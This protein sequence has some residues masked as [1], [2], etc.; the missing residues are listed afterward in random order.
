[1]SADGL[2]PAL[3][4]QFQADAEARRARFPD[5]AWAERIVAQAAD[6]ACINYFALKLARQAI[7]HR[8]TR[9]A[10]DVEVTEVPEGKQ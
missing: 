5:V 8:E 3:Q 4:Q 1:M 9:G 7:G 6:G 10:I 2:I